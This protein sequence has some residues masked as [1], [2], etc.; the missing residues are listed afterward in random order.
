MFEKPLF[1]RVGQLGLGLL[2]LGALTLALTGHGDSR[3]VRL[4]ELIPLIHVLELP[5]AFRA[6][7]RAGAPIAQ[8]IVGTLLFGFFWWLP[9]M[10]GVYERAAARS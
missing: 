7:K 9:V 4:A 8:V 3:V 2:Y 6:T 10:R 5:V 1:W